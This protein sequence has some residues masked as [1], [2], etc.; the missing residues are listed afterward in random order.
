VRD[1]LE[2]EG[3]TMDGSYMRQ[4]ALAAIDAER[5]AWRELVTTVGTDRM[6]EPGPMG[7]W[8]FKDLAAHLT[9][10]RQYSIARIVAVHRGEGVPPPPWP[11]EFTTDD[12]INE[13]IYAREHDRPLDAVL[14]DADATFTRLH[15]IVETMNDEELTDPTRFPWMEGR[16]LSDVIISRYY[17][18]HLHEEH[19]PD[20]RA[21]L[22]SRNAGYDQG[23]E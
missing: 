3:S 1:W 8:T 13:W 5:A 17:F 4:Q 15:A 14:A 2:L 21:W 16:S 19:E 22:D 11:Q 20:L 7:D 10:W 12:E 9:G 23:R 6:N 18:A